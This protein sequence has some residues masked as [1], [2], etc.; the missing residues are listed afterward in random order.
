[1][2]RGHFN[3]NLCADLSH[4]A[5]VTPAVTPAPS[6][7]SRKVHRR[8]A[9]LK[10]AVKLVTVQIR[11]HRKNKMTQETLT[12]DIPSSRGTVEELS[13]ARSSKSLQHKKKAK[14]AWYQLSSP[15]NLKTGPQTLTIMATELQNQAK[16][17]FIWSPTWQKPRLALPLASLKQWLHSSPGKWFLIR[18][19][20]IATKQESDSAQQIKAPPFLQ[21][22]RQCPSIN[23][24]ERNP[25]INKEASFNKYSNSILPSKHTSDLLCSFLAETLCKLI[26]R[27]PQHTAEALGAN[28]QVLRH[29]GENWGKTSDRSLNKPCVQLQNHQSSL[30]PLCQSVKSILCRFTERSDVKGMEKCNAIQAFPGLSRIL[31]VLF[32]TYLDKT[33]L[34]TQNQITLKISNNTQ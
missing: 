10:Q 16:I 13:K 21:A 19:D 6:P 24:E 5:A 11:V 1:M 28:T 3:G 12:E 2:G 31:S 30:H 23:L 26:R 9:I 34:G 14:L 8:K 4:N 27:K 17:F 33:S 22:K 25:S 32:K 7:S 20:L 18:L 15:K 29:S